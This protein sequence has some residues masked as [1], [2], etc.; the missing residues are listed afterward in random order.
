[1]VNIII[2]NWNG[3]EITL[4]C[5]NSLLRIKYH[6]FK[7]IVVDNGSADK[8]KEILLE[9]YS[10]S[11]SIEIIALEKNIGFTGGNNLAIK[12]AKEKYNPDYYLLLNNDTI[13]D[14][15]FLD[16]MVGTIE[17]SFDNYAVV[18]KI[19]Y[20]GDEKIINF[21]GGV[22]SKL[23]GVAKHYGDNKED[24]IKYNDKKE[25]GFMNGCCALIRRQSINDIGI[26][27]DIFFANSEDSD[28]SLRILKAGKKIIY[29]PEAVIYHKANYSFKANKGKWF[30]FYLGTRNI[31]LLQKKHLSFWLL[32]FFFFAFSIRWLAY[33]T[34]KL[35]LIGDFKSVAALYRGAYHG[36]INKIS[37]V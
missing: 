20:Y 9:Q 5:I 29:C 10:E 17:E 27:D 32:P 4:E 13:V 21:A 26:L 1:M 28:Y 22:I 30:A 25:T 16:Y 24:S 31:I 19:F 8:S 14:P 33:M 3:I 6:S 18:P 7:I 37:Y 23:T 11:N 34:L 35:T 15:L 36:L 12:Y 2:L